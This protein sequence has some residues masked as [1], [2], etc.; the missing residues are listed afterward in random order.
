MGFAREA[1]DVL[2]LSELK[3]PL[4]HPPEAVEAAILKRLGIAPSQLISYRL[5]KRSIDARRHGR[6]QFIYSADVV[7]TGEVALLKR[8][9]SNSKIR[10]APDTDYY[11]VAKA[12][13]GFS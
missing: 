10:K 7:V 3:L 9:S 6:I 5:V 2:R 12:P 11:P 13:S 8:H 4:D 1:G